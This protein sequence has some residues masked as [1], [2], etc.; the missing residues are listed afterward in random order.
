MN[1]VVSIRL[2]TAVLA[3]SILSLTAM[4]GCRQSRE[5]FTDSAP[6]HPAIH[7]PTRNALHPPGRVHA[8]IARGD[9]LSL[10]DDFPDD[11]YLPADY[12]I[13]SLMDRGLLRVVSL[14]VPGHVSTLFNDARTNMDQ[15]GWTQTLAM[16]DAGDSALLNYEKDGRAA[17]L[18]F[19]DDHG[20][21]GVT[22]N[23]QLR[24]STN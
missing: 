15:R 16:R 2:P 19:S 13:N 5:A 21:G 20:K 23:V 11:I 8:V 14:R 6:E 10:P 9:V 1:R 7:L 18:S 24:S 4:S 3:L 12:R 22:M 17:V